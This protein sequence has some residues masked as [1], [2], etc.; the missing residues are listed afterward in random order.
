[1]AV[2]PTWQ[3]RLSQSLDG[4]TLTWRDLLWASAI[5]HPGPVNLEQV[6]V[7]LFIGHLYFLQMRSC[8]GTI[9]SVTY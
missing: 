7:R 4:A 5:D 9:L 6:F 3:R 1:M 8:P 2:F